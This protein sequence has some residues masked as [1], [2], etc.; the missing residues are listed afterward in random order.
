MQ[1]HL[2]KVQKIISKSI[3]IKWITRLSLNKC[4]VFNF[5]L[6][7]CHFVP[8]YSAISTKNFEYCR[9]FAAAC[10]NKAHKAQWKAVFGEIFAQFN[11]IKNSKLDWIT[12][13]ASIK[14]VQG[15]SLIKTCL[16]YLWDFVHGDKHLNNFGNELCCV[17]WWAFLKLIEIAK[18]MF[19]NLCNK[20]L[21]KN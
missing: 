18:K 13:L 5:Y 16:F 20:N 9:I 8:F 7:Y 21:H 10:C 19:E 4:V 2:L 11:T 17:V 14:E 3:K 12:K 15:E 6:I 1:S